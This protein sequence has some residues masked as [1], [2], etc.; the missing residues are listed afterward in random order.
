MA[1][2]SNKATLVAI[3]FFETYFPLLLNIFLVVEQGHSKLPPVH[4]RVS[5]RVAFTLL[6]NAR[7]TTR[8]DLVNREKANCPWICIV[9]LTETKLRNCRRLRQLYTK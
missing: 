2:F 8:A 9:F 6:V 4:F 5:G 3:T 7:T 1:L